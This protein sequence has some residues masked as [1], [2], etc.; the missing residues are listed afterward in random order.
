MLVQRVSKPSVGRGGSGAEYFEMAYAFD[1]AVS[2]SGECR[3]RARELSELLV[4][5]GANVFYDDF[6]LEYLLGKR[7]DDEFSSVFG[8]ATRF[9]VPFVSSEYAQRAWPQYEWSVGKLEAQRRHEEFILP[10]RVDDTVL[11]GLLDT[12][13]YLDLRRMEL[14]EVANI[15]IGKLVASTSPSEVSPRT[16]KWVVTFGLLMGNLEEA[17]LPVAAPNRVPMLYDWLTEEL[18]D[19]LGRTSLSQ[20][21]VIEDSRDGETLS[22]RLGFDWDVSKGAMDFG[23]MGWWD[24]L[25]LAPYEDIYGPIDGGLE[26]G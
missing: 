10:L 22:V 13:C 1:F 11:V 2:F 15:L 5:K 26:T 7:L 17:E 18:V 3:S 25:E 8:E 20:I 21:R 14:R 24:L 16:R 12:V 4:E 19:R 6:Y 9:F 23:D